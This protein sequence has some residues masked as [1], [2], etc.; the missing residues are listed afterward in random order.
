METTKSSE[1]HGVLLMLASIVFFAVNVLMLRGITLHCPAADGYVASVYRGFWGLL[2]VWLVF[3]GR[4]FQPGRLVT[5]PILLLRGGVGA[6]GILLFYLTIEHLGAGRATI[7]NLTYPIFGAL[8][9]AL[10]LKERLSVRQLSW[11]LAALGGL[12]VFFADTALRAR[13]SRHELLAALGAVVA[14]LAVVLIRVLGRSEHAS[15]I[16]ASQCIWTVVVAVPMCLD[17]L[18]KLP[19]W[20]VLGLV[21]ASLMV[22]A[23]QLAL[24]QAFRHLSVAMGSSLQMLLPVMI[25]VGG[26]T[27]FGETFTRIEV[28]GAI[29]TLFATWRSINPGV[30]H[31][32]AAR[33]DPPPF[34]EVRHGNL[35]GDPPRTT[36]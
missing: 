19:A 15:T 24:T 32:G 30:R 25:A 36:V 29:V 7:I 16:Y 35:V 28:L 31:K 8:M 21:L 2:A 5:R 17:R 26:V 33:D 4:G 22:T 14:G 1:R 12:V 23:G 6:A 18:F 9:A 27:M 10:W 34:R 11:M 13:I 3:R 20:A